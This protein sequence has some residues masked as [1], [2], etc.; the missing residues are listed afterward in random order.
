MIQINSKLKWYLYIRLYIYIYFCARK[1]LILVTY[2]QDDKVDKL[3][4]CWTVVSLM[5]AIL[6][7]LLFPNFFLSIPLS[8]PPL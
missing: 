4:T 6:F 8:P 1:I 5:I 3:I 2:Y 7:A